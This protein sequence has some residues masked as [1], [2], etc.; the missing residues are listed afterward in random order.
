L[1]GNDQRLS[2]AIL[3]A[4]NN[5]PLLISFLNSVI[6]PVSPIVVVD[7]LNPYNEKEFIGDKLSIVD[8]K[9]QDDQKRLFQI[10]IQMAIFPHLPARMLYTWSDIYAAQLQDGEKY[11]DLHPVISIWLLSENLFTTTEVA[12]HHFQMADMAQQKILNDHCSLHVL[13]LNKWQTTP[14]L[15]MEDQWMIF[16]REA[17]SWSELPA[18][19][20]TPEL[21]QAM[22]TL[23]RFSE[24]EQAYHL[25]Q[26]RENAIREEKTQQA[27]LEE[28]LAKHAEAVRKQEEERQ[29]K[30]EERSA[31]EAALANQEIERK[32]KEEE[33]RA[34][35]EAILEQERLR[36]MLKKSG[37]DP[38]AS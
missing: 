33:R 27:L 13:E 18:Q 8:I 22:A 20:N 7:I 30:E 1:V 15:S 9:A 29:A 19:L 10:E 16:F 34:K 32:A 5:K 37:I 35:E 28:A 24:K 3:G 38:D 2:D 21:R 25:Y 31:K 23:Q 6:K 12:H 4:E 26:A 14:T 11:S 36:E 17:K